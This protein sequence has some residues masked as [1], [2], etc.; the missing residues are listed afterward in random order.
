MATFTINPAPR[1]SGTIFVPATGGV[2]VPAN[3][4]TATVSYVM[5]VD[6][7][8][9]DT[10]ARLDFSIDL[11]TNGGVTWKPHLNAGWVG[12]TGG[13][14][15]GSTVLNPPPSATLG[16]DFFGAYAGADVRIA[17]VLATPMTVGLTVTVT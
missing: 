12:G 4:H 1:S 15:K 2:T 16:G 7:E 6:A 8:R 14:N 10:N 11:S 13:T 17:T 9:A 3:A 5:P